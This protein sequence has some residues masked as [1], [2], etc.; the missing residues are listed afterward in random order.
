M[1]V[2][3]LFWSVP[4]WRLHRAVRRWLQVVCGHCWTTVAS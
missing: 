2:P 3:L 4:A 1:I